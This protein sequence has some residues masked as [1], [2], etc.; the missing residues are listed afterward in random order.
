MK[1]LTALF[2]IMFVIGMINGNSTF[3]DHP[4]SLEEAHATT[5]WRQDHNGV[6]WSSDGRSARQDHN[7]VWWIE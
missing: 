2:V 6:L 4:F 5:S 7:G 3:P 1:I